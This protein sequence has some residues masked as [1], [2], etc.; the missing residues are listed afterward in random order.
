M[1]VPQCRIRDRLYLRSLRQLVPCFF[2]PFQKIFKAHI[3]KLCTFFGRIEAG[4]DIAVS[5]VFSAAL[6][7]K[8]FSGSVFHLKGHDIF[9]PDLV[10]VVEGYSLVDSLN[11]L[12]GFDLSSL[13]VI[14]ESAK[15][16]RAVIFFT[17]CIQNDYVGIIL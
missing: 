9:P 6:F 17:R 12:I 1:A 2:H 4:R 14:K 16:F 10:F 5:R 13:N 11:E 7:A 15:F 8:Y 3:E